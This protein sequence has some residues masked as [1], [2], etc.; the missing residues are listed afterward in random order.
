[1]DRDYSAPLA[2]AEASPFADFAHIPNVFTERLGNGASTLDSVDSQLP[3]RASGDG[4]MHDTIMSDVSLDDDA[5]A[6]FAH[7]PNVFT[8]RLGTQDTSLSRTKTA[9]V[10][11][12]VIQLS[13]RTEAKRRSSARAY[14]G[15]LVAGVS[16][17]V[18]GLFVTSALSTPE[19]PRI[20]TAEASPDM[21]PAT[22]PTIEVA[23][24]AAVAPR[25]TT[26]T[27]APKVVAPFEAK[28]GEMVGVLEIPGIC[29]EIQVIEYSEQED[30]DGLVG[31]GAATIDRKIPDPTVT[32]HC[33]NVEAYEQRVEQETVRNHIT[34]A[35]RTRPS[36]ITSD[37]PEG[38]VNKLQPIAGHATSASGDGYLS[39][40]P[41]QEGNA[42]I[43]GH[44]ST[45]SAPFAD[46]AALKNG[47]IAIF[48]RADGRTFI[49][50]MVHKEILDDED[51]LDM[52]NYSHPDSDKTLTLF[53]CVD[54]D[55]NTG[56]SAK[57]Y[58]VRMIQKA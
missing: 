4:D 10:H 9:A 49:Y 20:A 27:E 57:R 39:V 34:R 55:G 22:V 30:L 12:D 17:V 43:V 35:E 18:G 26:T 45:F 58:V 16:F 42:V 37:N 40:F 6:D 41:G 46:L 3:E 54:A 28:V 14:I 7:I 23:P 15:S 21:A 36:A 33:E 19:R 1:M 38:H 2:D 31:T 29:E 51:Y 47:D 24:R 8:E 50:E 48:R 52:L 53:M 13:S 56:S 32:E 11:P 44:G 25:Q 5:F